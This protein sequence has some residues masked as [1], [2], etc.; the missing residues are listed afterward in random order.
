MYCINIVIQLPLERSPSPLTADLANLLP[1][2]R[3][4]ESLFLKSSKGSIYI[5]LNNIIPTH[6][7]H[8]MLRRDIAAEDT[9]EKYP[10]SMYVENY[11]TITLLLNYSHIQL[12]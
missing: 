2:L 7:K 1:S 3:R 6:P 11:Q 12:A 8:P 4:K 9:C 10:F 5:N